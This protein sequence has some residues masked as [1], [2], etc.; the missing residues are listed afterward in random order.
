MATRTTRAV[1]T[2]V[3]ELVEQVRVDGLPLTSD[4]AEDFKS[5][6]LGAIQRHGLTE[7]AEIVE[8]ARSWPGFRKKTRSPM[9]RREQGKK[10]RYEWPLFRAE[11]NAVVG[12]LVLRGMPVH[13]ARFLARP[14]QLD[15]GTPRGVRRWRTRRA[16]PPSA[17]PLAVF[18]YMLW[19]V[20][21]EKELPP[22]L[23]RVL[24]QARSTTLWDAKGLPPQL[25]RLP[26][27][28]WST[29]WR[30]V[31]APWDDGKWKDWAQRLQ[32]DAWADQEVTWGFGGDHESF[33]KVFRMTFDRLD[34]VAA[35]LCE[36][37]ESVL[38]L[39]IG[40]PGACPE[41]EE[42][43][44]AIAARRRPQ[45]PPST[46]RKQRPRMSRRTP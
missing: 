45:M 36:E 26:K 39:T 21:P 3:R 9:T 6:L 25:V 37:S 1:L 30:H 29:T 46:A 18:C 2:I 42:L 44:D 17:W 34:R 27:A 31:L 8:A 12:V 10:G 7:R 38:W 4:R 32:I 22:H 20:I 24:P 40:E 35:T 28:P 19:E 43:M 23:A 33:K 13:Q 14:R 11:V 41:I 16:C 5:Y 15:D